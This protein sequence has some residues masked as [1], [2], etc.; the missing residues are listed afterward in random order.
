MVIFIAKQPQAAFQSNSPKA[1]TGLQVTYDPG[2]LV[3]YI[4]FI[5]MIIGCYVSFFTS[6]QQVFLEVSVKDNQQHLF[7]CG[8]SNKDKMGMKR[9]IAKLKAKLIANI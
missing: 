8:T 2:V 6:H 3:V 5:L 7:L 1:Y 9:N 4:G